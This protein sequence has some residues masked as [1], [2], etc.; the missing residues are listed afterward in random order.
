MEIE[1]RGEPYLLDLCVAFLSG[2]VAA[3]AFANT[4]L[5]SSIAG[6]AI[7]AALVPPLA[8]VGV[9]LMIGRPTISLNGMSLTNL[10]QSMSLQI[11]SGKRRQ[12]SGSG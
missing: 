8:V 3:Y 12:L 5:A 7:A 9:A 10:S 4:K 6:V 11:F 2:F 1:A